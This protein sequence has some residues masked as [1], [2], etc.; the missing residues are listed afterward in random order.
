[1]GRLGRLRWQL[2]LAHLDSI[3]CT[4][5]AMVGAI[6]LITTFWF[7]GEESANAAAAQQA[8]TVARAISGMV[9]RG[10]PPEEINLVL[11][12]LV[13]GDLQLYA[14]YGPPWASGGRQPDWLNTGLRDVGYIVIFDRDG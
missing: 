11:G 5:V 1:M 7:H 13:R 14:G 3:G 2:T 8:R 9:A 12:A 4:L 6:V 10:E